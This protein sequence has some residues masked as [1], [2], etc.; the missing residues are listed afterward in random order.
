MNEN[1]NASSLIRFPISHDLHDFPEIRQTFRENYIK[2]LS[3]QKKKNSKIVVKNL[4]AI[5]F[6]QVL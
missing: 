1:V 3:H 6:C 4:E 2:A 5:L